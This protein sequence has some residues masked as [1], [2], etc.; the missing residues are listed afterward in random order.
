M[1]TPVI[2]LFLLF[3]ISGNI[4]ATEIIIYNKGATDKVKFTAAQ[5]KKIQ[6][7]VKDIYEKA[8]KT[9]SI[10]ISKEDIKGIKKKDR[11]VEIIFDVSFPFSNGALGYESVKRMLIPLNGSF[12]GDFKNGTLNFFA[13]L[14][15]YNG[16]EYSNT[17]G[18]K[19]IEQLYKVLQQ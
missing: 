17:N 12:A 3:V 16:K 13:G 10:N 2:F 11:C 15:D 9:L 8:D 5:E 14:D 7:I 4:S 19:Y 18:F 1:K 6:E